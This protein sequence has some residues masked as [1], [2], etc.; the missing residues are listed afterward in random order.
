MLPRALLDLSALTSGLVAKNRVL[1]LRPRALFLAT[2]P[3]AHADKSNR[4]LGPML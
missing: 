3:E 4:A 2:R 1:A